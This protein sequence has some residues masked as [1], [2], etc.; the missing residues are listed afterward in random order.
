MLVEI[1]E[2][3][4]YNFLFENELNI[5]ENEL[6]ARNDRYHHLRMCLKINDNI[7]C[8]LDELHEINDL[9]FHHQLSIVYSD[10]QKGTTHTFVELK[11]FN[12]FQAT[13][14]TQTKA[15]IMAT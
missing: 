10:C 11:Y 8:E 14:Y 4:K 6:R 7:L 3:H 2:G 9:Y 1:N 5:F 13:K 15:I 12:F